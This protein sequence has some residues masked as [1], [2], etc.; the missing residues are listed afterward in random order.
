MDD[1]A[2]PTSTT[3]TTP[4]P[5]RPNIRP[6][7]WLTSGQL[8]RETGLPQ[9]RIQELVAEGLPTFQMDRRRFLFDR[10][11]AAEWLDRNEHLTHAHRNAIKPLIDNAP[12]LTAEQAAQIK[13]P[14]EVGWKRTVLRWALCALTVLIFVPLFRPEIAWYCLSVQG[15]LLVFMAGIIGIKYIHR[16][17]APSSARHG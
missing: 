13:E 14:P 5:K 10:D 3:T 16:S 9:N 1:T 7:P 17:A 4:L 6:A 2:A 15:S 12:P 8:A 11:E